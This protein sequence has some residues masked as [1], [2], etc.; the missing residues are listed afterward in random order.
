MSLVFDTSKWCRDLWAGHI[1]ASR[2]AAKIVRDGTQKQRLFPQ[3]SDDI[4]A[5]LYL[6]WAPPEKPKAPA[7]A[8]NL[9]ASARELPEW[10]QLR[11]RVQLNAFSAGVAA[12]VLLR[13]L[14]DQVPEQPP[15]KPKRRSSGSQNQSHPQQPQG[16]QEDD[17]QN[18]NNP[19]NSQNPQNG[20]NG[21]D[22]AAALRKALRQA[23]REASDA[24]DEAEPSVD[25]LAEA[26]GINAGHGLGVHQSLHDLD[27]IRE[28]YELLR[29]ND[30]LR[31]IA[32]LAGRLQRIG[33]SHKRCRVT[34]AEGGIKDVVLGGDLS[35]ILPGELAGLRSQNRLLRLM[36]LQ[37]IMGRQALQYLTQG[38]LPETRGPI[39][40][41]IDESDSMNYHG[42]V[43]RDWSKAVAMALLTTATQQKRAWHFIGFTE[44]ITHE[45]TVLPG[46]LTLDILKQTILRSCDGGTAFEPPIR[47]AMEVLRE[48]PTMRKSD[49]ILL[50][51][52]DAKISP[53]VIEEVN[54]LKRETSCHLYTIGIGPI[55]RR[56]IHVF[57]PIA[58]EIY[59]VSSRPDA[60][61]EK[62]APIIALAS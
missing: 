25:A 46:E 52:G 36:T 28:L 14:I 9:L 37:K 41:C 4:H 8:T 30:T 31:R 60:D 6:R 48:A 18:G 40:C 13:G 55:A 56:K 15:A 19:Q 44:F 51:D 32:L 50:T 39:I 49:V 10:G 7:W 2:S 22:D 54:R 1:Q 61:S 45:Q 20:T 3:L 26:L 23:C 17:P 38:T 58:D 35:K 43:A 62:V 12:E 42:G 11:Q 47:R 33:A 29:H 21:A 59:L 27:T 16:Q 34:P 24:V 53:E 5:A 57:D